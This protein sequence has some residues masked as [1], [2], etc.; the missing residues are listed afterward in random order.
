MKKTKIVNGRREWA[1]K[2]HVEEIQACYANPN[3]GKEYFVDVWVRELLVDELGFLFMSGE[4][5]FILASNGQE[6]KVAITIRWEN[7]RLVFPYSHSEQEPEPVINL[8]GL[9]DMI[10]S[11]WEAESRMRN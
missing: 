2:G 7:G 4:Q 9:L 10:R 1:N 6:P 8:M 3:L 5:F 11:K